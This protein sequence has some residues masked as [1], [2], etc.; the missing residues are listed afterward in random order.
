MVRP[1]DAAIPP[2]ERLFRKVKADWLDGDRLLEDAIDLRG[3]SCARDAYS[4]P[5]DLISPTWPA[6]AF[7]RSE[8]LPQAVRPDEDQ[9]TWGWHSFDDPL[10]D[11]EAHCEIHIRRATRKDVQ[12]N[13][14]K[15]RERRAAIKSQLKQALVAAFRVFD[16]DLEGSESAVQPE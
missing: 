3:T 16:P 10:E 15:A 8:L 13:D 7:T 12:A 5:R 1:R 14:D 9:Q 11:D 2:T 6:I 4:K